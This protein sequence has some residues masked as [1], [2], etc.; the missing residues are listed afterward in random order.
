[1][2][3]KEIEELTGMARAN[4]RF[5][6]NEGLISPNRNANGYRDYS[7][8]DAEVLQKIKLL[9]SLHISLE[10]IKALHTGNHRL[11]DTSEQHIKQL[12]KQKSELDHAQRICTVM[13]QDG[14]SYENLNT[15]K[16]WSDY[17]SV[18]ESSEELAQDTIPKVRTPWRGTGKVVCQTVWRNFY[19]RGIH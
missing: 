6:E 8:Q 3:I 4:I 15:E 17:A 16:Y 10:E 18:M 19:N 5:Y 7:A 12:E 14:V 2:T 1:M 9:R 13:R 11:S